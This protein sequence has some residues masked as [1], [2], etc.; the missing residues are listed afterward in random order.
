[1]CWGPM[2]ALR[3]CL[4]TFQQHWHLIAWFLGNLEAQRYT[5]VRSFR[6]L[7]ASCAHYHRWK[8]SNMT[9]VWEGWQTWKC[10]I[11]LKVWHHL[12]STRPCGCYYVQISEFG[13]HKTQLLCISNTRENPE[14]VNSAIPQIQLILKMV[15]TADEKI[16]DRKQG[17]VSHLQG[18]MDGL[19]CVFCG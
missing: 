4:T 15:A 2:C 7:W 16:D 11:S 14:Y 18:R 9:R 10:D 17:V 1:M 3:V 6:L 5:F 13:N 12:T 19:A 8:S